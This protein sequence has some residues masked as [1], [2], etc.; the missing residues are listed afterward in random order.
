M[1]TLIDERPNCPL[2]QRPVDEH[3]TIAMS[4]E[5]SEVW[6]DNK[7][8]CALFRSEVQRMVDNG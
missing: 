2:C 1:T 8:V 5:E 4:D 6:V 7:L 3:F